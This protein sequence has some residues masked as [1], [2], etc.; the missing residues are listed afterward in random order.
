MVKLYG[1]PNCDTMKKVKKWFEDHDIE[2][3]FINFKKTGLEEGLLLSWIDQVGWENLLNKRGMMWRKLDEKTREN[4]DRESAI[5]IMLQTP[6][7]IRR[8][9][10]DT[11]GELHVGFSE[12]VYQTLFF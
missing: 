9:V 11:G 3:Q 4:I 1:I 2:Y 7:I 10:L 6:S 8:P 5:R 12:K